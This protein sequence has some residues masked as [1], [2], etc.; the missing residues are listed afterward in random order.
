[1]WLEEFAWLW[2]P[3]V[4]AAGLWIT[5]RF[6]ALTTEVRTLRE[7]VERL[8]EERTVRGDDQRKVA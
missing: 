5:W 4:C 6:V 2:L 7:R 1:M 8:E 3:I